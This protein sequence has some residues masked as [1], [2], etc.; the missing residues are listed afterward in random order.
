MKI[1]SDVSSF[2]IEQRTNAR[3]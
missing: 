3:I 2:V 1:S